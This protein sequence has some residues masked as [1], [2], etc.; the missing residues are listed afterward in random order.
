MKL[1]AGNVCA[2]IHEEGRLTTALQRELAELQ[3]I[4]FDHELDE[5]LFVVFHRSPFLLL[6]SLHFVNDTPTQQ[7]W[8]RVSASLDLRLNLLK[9]RWTAANPHLDLV[10]FTLG[11][12]WVHV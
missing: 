4:A 12:R 11:M 6:D 10:G 9:R 2:G 5:L 3:N 8:A 1:L 7:C